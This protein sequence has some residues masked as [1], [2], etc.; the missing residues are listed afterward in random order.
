LD[1]IKGKADLVVASSVINFVP[2]GDLS[3]TMK[4]IG[5]LLKTGG[6]FCHSDWRKGDDDP[7]G[8]DSEK[9]RKVH[10]HGMAGL[11]IKSTNDTSTFCMGSHGEVKAF[12][13]VARKP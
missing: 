8:F 4:V 12:V 6:L 9:A 3:G 11:E 5:E 2:S 10:R 7:D 1:S 13:G